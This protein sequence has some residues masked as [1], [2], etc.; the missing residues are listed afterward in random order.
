M[1]VEGDQPLDLIQRPVH[2]PGQRHQFLAR[3]PA[4][5]LLD[6]VQRR[7]QAR[8][9]ELARPGLD[10]GHALAGCRHYRPSCPLAA[11]GR[12]G[13][14]GPG[15]LDPHRAELEFG[16]L[17]DRV[18]RVGGQ[19]VG[20]RLAEV[21]RDEA[22]AALLAVRDA[23]RE[24]DGPAARAHPGHL[25]IGDAQAGG[26]GRV[27]VHLGQRRDGVQCVRPAGHRAGVPV[28]QQPAGVEHERVILARQLLGRQPLGRHQV[29]QPVIGVEL[30][31][32][33][34]HGAVAVLGVGV[35]LQLAG[36]PEVVVAE[37]GV[38]RHHRDDLLE[39]VPRAG[40]GPAEPDPVGDVL[41]RPPS[42]PGP[43]RA[44]SS[45]FRP[46]CTRRSVLV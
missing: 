26:V 35:R 15:G 9:G 12:G 24:H 38:A 4:D 7:D 43:A 5:P 18:D 16:D 45:T 29:G 2:V 36:Q 30:L 14:G 33:H 34:D 41:R 1:R 23:D 46:S 31:A 19:Q 32:E 39:H 28:L 20:R 17:A 13:L 11:G 44:A 42:P 25:A 21:E 37:V 6:R 8:A 27:Q 22:V 10:A 40:V 3:Q